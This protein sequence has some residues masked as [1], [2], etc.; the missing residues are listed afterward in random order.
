MHKSQSHWS[1]EKVFDCRLIRRYS[2]DHLT[3][4]FKGSM[5]AFFS[6]IQ[7]SPEHFCHRYAGFASL[8]TTANIPQRHTSQELDLLL[9]AGCVFWGHFINEPQ[10]LAGT[11]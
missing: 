6:Q 2:H 8:F 11:W 1:G 9:R 4:K 5:L 7:I 10:K 3:I